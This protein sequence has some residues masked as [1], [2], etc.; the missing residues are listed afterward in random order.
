MRHP[1]WLLNSSLLLLLLITL[2]FIGF[3]R[4]KVPSREPIEPDG[5]VQPTKEDVSHINIQKIY[6]TD[7]FNTYQQEFPQIDPQRPQVADTFPAP[8]VEQQVIVPEKPKTTFVEPL[9]IVLKG[10]I[11]VGDDDTKNK[12]IIAN[13]KTL[14]ENLYKKEDRIEDAQLIGIF[15][16]KVIFL[17]SNG[18]QEVLYLREKDVA[19]DP[20]YGTSKEWDNIIQPTGPHSFIVSPREFIAR[21]KNLAHFIDMLN[22][23]TVYAKGTSIGCRI[24]H[25]NENSLGAVLG[26]SSGDIVLSINEIPV[27]DTRNRLQAYK[28]I[29]EL[30]PGATVEVVIEK[31]NKET[32]LHYTLQE[33]NPFE[34]DGPEPTAEEIKREQVKILQQKHK[35][36]PTMKQI[37]Q[38]ERNMMRSHGRKPY[39]PPAKQE[40][41]KS[42]LEKADSPN[43]TE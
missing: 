31:R 6:E 11:I 41:Q 3:T 8:P 15:N 9:S 2:G 20:T 38:Q 1:L 5:Y 40:P 34:P 18:Q 22:L 43:K 4:E 33:L 7:L 27:T 17:R 32:T 14:Q 36:A 13:K 26:L 19:L 25:L 28:N 21:V 37:R 35:F 29:T 23:T 16:N 10:I 42:A 12:A 24:G 30:K 39:M